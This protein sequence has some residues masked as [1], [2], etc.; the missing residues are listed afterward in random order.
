MKHNNVKIKPDPMRYKDAIVYE[1]HVKAFCN[2]NGK[3]KGDG[4]DDFDGLTE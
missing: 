3:D 2:G 1:L 4:M